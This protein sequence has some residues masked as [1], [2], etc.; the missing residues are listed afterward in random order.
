MKTS[1]TLSFVLCLLFLC[2]DSN[3]STFTVVNTN[4][5]GLGSLRQA[6]LDAN[7]S[8]GLDMIGFNIPASGVQTISPTTQLP[9]VTD[10]AIIDGTSQPGYSGTPIVMIDGS[11]TGNA[12]GLLITSGSSA[13]R[14]LAI[15][16][17]QNSA[18]IELSTNGGNVVQGNYIG[19]DPDGNTR[20]R[21]QFGIGVDSPNNLIGGTLPSQRNVVAGSTFDNIGVGG[22]G[23]NN[24]IKGNFVG[25]NAAGTTS[26]SDGSGYGIDISNATSTG[27]VIGGTEPGAGNL[28]SG[29]GQYGILCNG[30]DSLIQGNLVGTD[31]S[32][33]QAIPNTSG[34]V[35]VS[36]SNI[37]L[38]GTTP[39]A[40]NIISGN[41]FI[42]VLA[43]GGPVVLRI[44]GNYIGVDITGNN[45]LG[46]SSTGIDANGNLQVGGTEPGAGNVISGNGVN[47][48]EA[49]GI[50]V[51]ATGVQGTKIEG[52]AIG[53]NAAGDIAIGNSG[54]SGISIYSTS[55]VVGGSQEGAGNVIGGN[56]VGIL[57]GAASAGSADNNLI[58]GNF[59]GTDRLSVRPLPNTIAGIRIS[60]GLN[61]KVGGANPGEGNVIAFNNGSGVWVSG[62]FSSA[63]GNTISRNLIYQNSALGIDLGPAGVTANDNCDPDNGA[64]QLQ[65][66]PVINSVSSNAGTTF[67]TGNL[68]SVANSIFTIEFFANQTANSS[69]NGEGR[70]YL[71]S[72]TVT[73]DGVC[74][75]PIN[76]S[77]SSRNVG[78]LLISAT[79]TDATGN[80]SEFS[81]TVRAT[82]T[83]S[84]SVFDFDGDGKSDEAVFR[85]SNQFWYLLRSEAGFTG[86]RFGLSS[87]KIT[88][89]DFDGDGKT[90]IAVFR[91][92]TWYWLN[93]STGG[94]SAYQFGQSGDIPLPADYTGD[95]RAELAVFRSGNWYTLNLANNQFQAVQFG[96]ST[97]K[98]VPADF[99]GDGKT[100]FAVYRDGT[101]YIQQSTAGFTG[102]QFGI[103][104]D[105]TVVGDYD[106]DGKADEAV[107][108]NGVWYILASSQGF[109]AIQFGI[110]TDL[111]VAADYD[112]DGKTDVAVFRDGTWYILRSQQGFTAVQFGQSNDKPI[113]S[114]Y[115]P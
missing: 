111:P 16:N 105:K 87:D 74:N 86:S 48:G 8:P 36:G 64:N 57:V 10:P 6:I 37:L 66:F 89:A 108:R 61:N 5:S 7:A 96:I 91:D 2:I 72:T 63:T 80:T 65:N 70:Y 55:I 110:S 50:I 100:D 62:P 93:S 44:K 115:L 51:R 14:G 101:W 71:G 83:V 33:T 22:P 79:A 21:N 26:L 9:T 60:A 42:G 19:V 43:S 28:V 30:R 95:G 15:G 20:R 32:G 88:P 56:A 109:S 113:P 49:G 17:F 85:P 24:Q 47:S 77:L 35:S 68:N 67:F 75:A 39:A 4:N 52:N 12:I 106:G 82:G 34:G 58:Q 73:T 92:G 114:A 41:G 25:T 98:P 13:V 90:D 45:P 27:N 11:T 99:D 81:N 78:S 53:V 23:L 46:N 84:R 3:A 104:T 40:R 102:V 31:I 59:I 18:A 112:G 29:N 38:G 76:V 54:R 69:G 1:Y 94:M 107:Y 103:A 97:D